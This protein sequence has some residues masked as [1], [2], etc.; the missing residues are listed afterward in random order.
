MSL[1]DKFLRMTSQKHQAVADVM[2]SI[3]S[4]L[5]IHMPIEI[6]QINDKKK[7]GISLL[8]NISKNE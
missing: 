8:S 6:R 3:A 5:Q 2:K 7:L 1:L 4:G